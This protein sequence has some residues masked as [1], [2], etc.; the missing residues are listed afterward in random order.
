[1]TDVGLA[2]DIDN[3]I[4]DNRTRMVDRQIGHA[5]LGRRQGIAHLANPLEHG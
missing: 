1:L 3:R 4:V 5:A 2:G